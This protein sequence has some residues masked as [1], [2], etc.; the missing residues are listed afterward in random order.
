MF[1]C[2]SGHESGEQRRHSEAR[3]GP[4]DSTGR[5]AWGAPNR[6]WMLPPSMSREK[7]APGS[8]A[9]TQAIRPATMTM[10]GTRH[11][12]ERSDDGRHAGRTR[13]SFGRNG[14]LHDQEIRRPIPEGEHE[15]QAEDDRRPGDHHAVVGGSTGCGPQMVNASGIRLKISCTPRSP[16]SPERIQGIVRTR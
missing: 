11:F 16:R 4:A 9:R 15:A 2:L 6:T 5:S 8:R 14:P 13:R 7:S 10:K 3:S 1:A 12:E